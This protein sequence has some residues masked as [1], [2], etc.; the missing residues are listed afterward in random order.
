M[1][2]LVTD[3]A[4]SYAKKGQPVNKVKAKINCSRCVTA[5]AGLNGSGKT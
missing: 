3:C 2:L 4:A 1:I 5:G